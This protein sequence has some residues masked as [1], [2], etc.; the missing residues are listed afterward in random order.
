MKPYDQALDD[1]KEQAIKLAKGG[2]WTVLAFIRTLY[3]GDPSR[4]D[5]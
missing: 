3:K 4:I 2:R 5:W 1:Q